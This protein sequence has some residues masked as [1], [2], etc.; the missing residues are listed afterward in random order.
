MV[1]QNLFPLLGA[2]PRKFSQ[3]APFWLVKRM[4]KSSH[5]GLNV[6]ELN[7]HFPPKATPK[8]PP[9]GPN[10]Q[11]NQLASLPIK[12]FQSTPIPWNTALTLFTRPRKVPGSQSKAN[13]NPGNPPR[14]FKS[15]LPWLLRGNLPSP[16][17]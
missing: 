4:E 6:R 9:N 1:P 7:P 2:P 10:N 16:I 14:A 17:N 3:F 5:P 13:K 8:I 15:F 11:A 12:A